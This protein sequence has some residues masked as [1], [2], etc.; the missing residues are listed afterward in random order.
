MLPSRMDAAVA[1]A[2][3]FVFGPFRLVPAEHA[4]F[5]ND[6]ALRVGS[7]ALEVLHALIE[8]AGEVVS[9]QELM[10][11]VWGDTFV[12]DGNLRV[13]VAAIRKTLSD[14]Q[15]GARYITNVPGRGYCFV[16]PVTRS[17]LSLATSAPGGSADPA[18]ASQ[19][20]PGGARLP[21]P[22]TKM[23]GRG[24]QL[25]AVVDQ[26]RVQRL[27]TLVGPGGIGKTTVALAVAAQLGAQ[28]ASPHWDGV[29]FV[30]LGSIE[31]PELV[32]SA[33]ATGV[34][35]PGAS[36]NRAIELAAYLSDKAM[37]LVLD[38]CEHVVEAVAIFAE[39]ILRLAPGIRILATSREPL[40][41][42]G[43]WI[44]RLAPLELPPAQ[45]AMTAAEAL[46]YSGVELFVARAAASATGFELSD[47]DAP[48]VSEICRRLDGM[49]LAIELAAAR[50]DVFGVRGLGERLDASFGLLLQGRRTTTP[51]QR[52][53]RATLDWS[54][55]TLPARSQVVL[56]R[57]SVFK[58]IFTLESAAAV[59][60]S[61][62]ITAADV[63]DSVVD[64]TSK[65]LI[66]ADV[67]GDVVTY[68]LLEMTRAYAAEKLTEDG[69]HGRIARQHA[70]HQ[71]EVFER[72]PCAGLGPMVAVWGA[73]ERWRLPDLRAALDWSFAEGG[74]LELG[75]KLTVASMPLWFD[76]S[77]M[78]EYRGRVER[79]LMHVQAAGPD[80]P[81]TTST[82]ELL[83][84]LAHSQLLIHTVG[85]VVD[86]KAATVRALEIAE[87]MGASP[88]R[89]Q[90]L[91]AMWVACFARA[92]H[93]E[94]AEVAERFA[95]ECRT[96]TSLSVR[97][98]R[99][100][101]LAG[102]HHY[103]GRYDEARRLL[104]PMLHLPASRP[105][106]AV[107]IFEV[108]REVTVLSVLARTMWLQGF[109]TRAMSL[110]HDCVERAIRSHSAASLCFALVNAACPIAI[111]SGD[112]RT[113]SDWLAMLIREAAA[114]HLG[115]WALW[116]RTFEVA[117]GRG[118]RAVLDSAIR[119]NHAEMV[120]TIA[121]WLVDQATFERAD[122]GSIGWC[123]PEILRARALQLVPPRDAA[124]EQA[125][126]AL[127][128]R[129]LDLAAA[130]GALS[131]EL[132]AATSLAQLRRDQG[133]GAEARSIVE[134]VYS[135]FTEGLETSDLV[136]A[137]GFLA[138]LGPSTV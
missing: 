26:L 103:G 43:E 60:A 4:L 21:A 31:S 118:D 70:V 112:H 79:A 47:G 56:R 107:G 22:L 38:N 24:H 124:A 90:A 50:V 2:E 89:L 68:R 132:R 9:K 137:R 53:L 20:T 92:E 18:V 15:T 82:Q 98:V 30:E 74:D 95:E 117:L 73:E 131:W 80:R 91:G 115:G 71:C 110:A 16:A 61:D 119:P 83:L 69:D 122:T 99:D 109:P 11:R 49:P 104:E 101:L 17:A 127:L 113:A 12:E 76:V 128:T 46:R 59:S 58:G 85:P 88:L 65:S 44:S 96:T 138:E 13:H 8:R 28:L 111:W 25:V 33:I 19:R 121:P 40:R 136:A 93:V 35:L 102:S 42:E 36:E 6:K 1:S 87:T 116:G 86:V 126:E 10:A 75:V 3:T 23:I 29:R 62:G 72:E 78:D 105:R 64:L 14:G 94:A 130:Q 39:E 27:V 77:L 84:L 97:L 54:Y 41:V 134:R 125:V 81:A 55:E 114:H 7:R 51:R 67:S 52:T 32:A 45:A 106:P 129:A 48:I 57:L 100:M 120:G 34:E 108:D 133:R 37:L 5:E 135:R 66:A 63:I 123:A